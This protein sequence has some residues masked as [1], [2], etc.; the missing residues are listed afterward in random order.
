ME[1]EKK[2]IQNI[3]QN[4]VKHIV[5]LVNVHMEKSVDLHMEKMNF[6]QKIL[7]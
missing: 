5:K 7:E 3:K 2:K 4:Y 1:E 6:F